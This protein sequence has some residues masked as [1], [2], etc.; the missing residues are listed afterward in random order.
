[1]HVERALRPCH[2]YWL[3]EPCGFIYQLVVG[4]V[5]GELSLCVI[6]SGWK[7]LDHLCV[8]QD[9]GGFYLLGFLGPI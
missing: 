7:V 3:G 5:Q 8:T 6:I 1:M 2:A 4:E 9:S